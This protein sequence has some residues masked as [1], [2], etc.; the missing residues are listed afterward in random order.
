MGKDYDASP[1]YHYRLWTINYLL[2][3]LSRIE[4]LIR[5]LRNVIRMLYKSFIGSSAEIYFLKFLTTF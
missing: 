1:W 5:L 4:I 2:I 3:I